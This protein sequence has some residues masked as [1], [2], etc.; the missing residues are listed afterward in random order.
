MAFYRS[1]SNKIL[2]GVCGGI[3]ERL[4]WSPT[5]VRVLYVLLSILSAGFPGALVYVILWLAVPETSRT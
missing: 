2:G 3:A 4:D 5:V 1:R